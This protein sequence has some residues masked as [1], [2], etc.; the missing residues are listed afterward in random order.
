VSPFKLIAF[1]VNLAI[2][3]YLLFAKRL[4]GLRGGAAAEEELRERD[5]GVEALLRATP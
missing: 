5:V 1:I 2:V 4:F 3:I